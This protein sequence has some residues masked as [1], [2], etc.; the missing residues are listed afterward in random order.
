MTRANAD[1]L[2]LHQST[3]WRLVA[4]T[5]VMSVLTAAGALAVSI[6][7]GSSLV[8]GIQDHATLVLLRNTI[9]LIA[10]SRMSMEEV[11]NMELAN[12]RGLL[13]LANRHALAELQAYRAREISGAL[14]P[15]RAREQAFAR[16]SELAALSPVP[17]TVLDAGLTVV[18]HARAAMIGRNMTA[19]LDREGLPVYGE[20]LRRARTLDGAASVY[21]A[22]F[23][24]G[25]DQDGVLVSGLYFP[26]WDL[27][28]RSRMSMGPIE[29]AL[30][31][32]NR[33][34]F[35]ELKAR[36]REIGIAKS[37]YMTITD[38]DCNVLAH[39]NIEDRNL[40]ELPV[41]GKNTDMCAMIVATAQR[42]WGENTVR[43]DWDRP[44]DLG[45]FTHGKIMWATQEPTTGWYVVATAYVSELEAGVPRFFR[46]IFLPSL[47]SIVI[48]GGALALILRSMLK[49]V[50]ELTATCRAVA[51]GDLERIAPED[52]P[53]EIGYLCRRFNEMIRSLR[54]LRDLNAR[55]R[56]ELET[57]NTD[58]ERI[59]RLRT[60]AVERKAR[61]L[62]EMNNRLQELD[63]MKSAFL[64]SVSH[65][66]R[67][68]LT[69][70]MGFAKLIAKDFRGGFLP[71]AAG[72]PPRHDRRKADR[73]LEN[74]HVI[75]DEGERLTRLINDVL[76]L[77]RIESGRMQ[78]R[79][80]EFS[81]HDVAAR[82][83]DALRVSPR[84]GASVRLVS[85]VPADLPPV[86]AD[87]DRILQVLVNLLGNAV[88]F[89]QRGSI[90]LRAC[91]RDGWL[92][93]EVADTGA[94]IRRHELLQV[95]DKFHQ[96][97]GG[98][99]L[100]QKPAGTGLGLSI[101]HNILSRY[102]GVIWAESEFGRGATIRFEMP[103][104]G[105]SAVAAER[106]KEDA[107]GQDGP[108][109]LVVDD[110]PAIRAFLVDV[111]KDAGYRVLTAPD[112]AAALELAK[113]FRPDL[114]TLDVLMPVLD[115][116]ETARRLRADPDL[117]RTPI[118]VVSI[119]GEDEDIPADAVVEKPIDEETLL[120]AVRRLLQQEEDA[121]GALRD[122]AGK[123]ASVELVT[124][125][126]LAQR[127]RQGFDGVA[128]VPGNLA[129]A[130]D[131]KALARNTG[132]IHITR[133]GDDDDPDEL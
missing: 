71:E 54:D 99:T 78:W 98:D 13:D 117:A 79:D 16:L 9:D 123:D 119:L 3:F 105:A 37:G 18:A 31:E 2:A 102:G 75:S 35:N 5:L 104:D 53:G 73:I 62:E 40:R 43:Y 108:L 58:L 23:P 93:V 4:A 36:I 6:W 61:K 128:L 69:S 131:L 129:K 80:E 63:R 72:A 27:L 12:A 100:L 130:L 120:A 7:V 19:Y 107:A 59:V 42:E 92:Q 94:G 82:A 86:R 124:P 106:L 67:T 52:A 20:L 57:L 28:I 84:R 14:S 26:P 60:R 74:L 8:S 41:P 97:L 17:P 51:G 125:A 25:A 38:Q 109:V 64:S 91:H 89:T 76:D 66:L 65:E 1:H 96:A 50:R 55:R 34:S 114:I 47:M 29:A 68:P 44:D 10:R 15:H 103:V 70:I 122:R 113:E 33:S 127:L 32:L 11:H 48:L 112:G 45:H 83:V 85:E 81:F 77:A 49:P 116:R 95:F 39:P 88:K 22:T 126:E 115:G 24:D 121:P 133:F 111:L 87:A 101:C 21:L 118:L 110:E 132:A 30:A 90:R 56:G 46:S